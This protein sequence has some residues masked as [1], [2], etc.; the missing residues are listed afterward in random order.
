MA[1]QLRQGAIWTDAHT[2]D[3]VVA[4]YRR[5]FSALFRRFDTMPADLQKHIRYP[6]DLFY[7]QALQYRAYHM[8]APEVFYNREDLWQFPREPTGPDGVNGR[9]ATRMAPYY[10]MMRL[11]GDPHAEFFLM[12]PMVP[13]PT[14][15]TTTSLVIAISPHCLR[16]APCKRLARPTSR[17]ASLHR[18]PCG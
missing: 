7:I 18:T 5:I 4:T 8:D 1:E 2:T 6:E 9:N 16:L 11:P 13:S 14:K 3:P 17:R 15:P 10:I 12:L